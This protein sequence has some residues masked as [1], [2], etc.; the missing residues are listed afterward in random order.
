MTTV[1]DEQRAIL[2]QE[3]DTSRSEKSPGGGH[4]RSR[5]SVRA[6]FAAEDHTSSV[7]SQEPVGN[8]V[9]SHR[10]AALI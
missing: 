5:E 6:Q 3:A 1:G 8:M 9:I 2:C 10:G 4:D 7:S